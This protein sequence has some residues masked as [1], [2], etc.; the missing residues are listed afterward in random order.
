MTQQYWQC[1]SKWDEKA[2]M[3]LYAVALKLAGSEAKLKELIE[4]QRKKTERVK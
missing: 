4:E 1:R 2:F 3:D